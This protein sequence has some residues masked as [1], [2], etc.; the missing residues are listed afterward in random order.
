[1]SLL[2][3]SPQANAALPLLTGLAQTL[4]LPVLLLHA[5]QEPR[6]VR[7][8]EKRLAGIA[9]EL[10]RNGVDVAWRVAVGRPE[11]QLP[12]LLLARDLVLLGFGA[13][14]QP[15]RL[16]TLLLREAPQPIVLRRA[17]GRRVMHPRSVSSFGSERAAAA[18]EALAALLGVPAS[19]LAPADLADAER[20]LA[21]VDLLV[22]D[23]QAVEGLPSAAFDVPVLA[24]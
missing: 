16:T 5:A 24:V 19:V 14:P 8:A 22:V 3:G 15:G 9:H 10:R 23:R 7:P 18:A 1:M 2:D 12:P 6:R 17:G 4:D 13:R 11:E 20:R 21:P